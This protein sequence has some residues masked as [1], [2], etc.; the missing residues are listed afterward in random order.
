METYTEVLELEPSLK[1]DLSEKMKILLKEDFERLH[2]A[3]QELGDIPLEMFLDMPL[4]FYLG[5]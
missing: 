2:I 3:L 5:D 1:Q 4:E